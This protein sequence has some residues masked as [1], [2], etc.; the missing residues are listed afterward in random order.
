MEVAP[1]V[2]MILQLFAESCDELVRHHGKEGAKRYLNATREGLV[3]QKGIA[4]QL[5]IDDEER[6]NRL[7]MLGSYYVG[8]T[9]EDEAELRREFETLSSLMQD[10]DGIEWCDA[11]RLSSVEG[12]SSDFCCGIYFSN[13]AIIDSLG[14]PYDIGR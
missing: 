10:E 7:K 8:R 5:W 2:K 12:M 1:C 6:K 11:E 4:G 9:E 3:L 14:I 13:D